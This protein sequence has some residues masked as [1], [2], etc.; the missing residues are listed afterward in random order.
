[1]A[2]YRYTL[3]GELY[4]EA[5]MH[6]RFDNDMLDLMGNDRDEEVLEITYSDWLFEMIL[7]RRYY[8]EEDEDA[9]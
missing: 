2:V 7:H 9:R 3:T 1:M 8:E 5:D 6:G 4:D